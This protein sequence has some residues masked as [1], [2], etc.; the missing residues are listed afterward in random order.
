MPL[1]TLFDKFIDFPKLTEQTKTN[2]VDLI[3]PA[4]LSGVG[5]KLFIGQR[6]THVS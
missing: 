6:D 2:P 3:F 4:S 1:T 5:T